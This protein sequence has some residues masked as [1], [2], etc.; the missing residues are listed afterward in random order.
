MRLVAAVPASVPLPGQ[1]EAACHLAPTA[2]AYQTPLAACP[3]FSNIPDA[4]EMVEKSGNRPSGFSGP[5]FPTWPLNVLFRLAELVHVAPLAREVRT[6]PADTRV[7]G[8]TC[9][10][11]YLTSFR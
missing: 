8:F 2:S 6:V 11:A 9:L 7:C 10:T 3:D 4:S 1:I 5:F